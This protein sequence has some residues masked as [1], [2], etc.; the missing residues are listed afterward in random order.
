M[1]T[2]LPDDGGGAKTCPSCTK[3]YE[4]SLFVLPHNICHNC[5]RVITD[6]YRDD[7]LR[8]QK[9]YEQ[10]K[11]SGLLSLPEVVAYFE[12]KDQASTPQQ[13][14]MQVL[15]ERM[16]R[17]KRLLPYIEYNEP[18]YLAG[19][20]HKDICRRL[21]KFSQDVVDK[22]SPRLML[23]MPPRH[24]KSLIA[25]VNF[26]AWHLGNNPN[27]EIIACS[28]SASLAMK[29]S[30]K[31]RQQLR[32]PRY[33]ESFPNTK[34]SKDTQA[35]EEWLTTKGGGYVAAGVSGPITGKGAHVLIIDD[36]VKNRQDAESETKQEENIDWY[37]STAYTRLAP[38]GGVLIIL[39]RWHDADLAGKLI[40]MQGTG[41]DWEIVEYPAIATD[42]ELYRNKGEALHPDR[43][44]LAALTRIKNALPPRD[45]E[46]LYQQRP[47]AD[48]GD[49]FK[50]DD[51]RFF[52]PR[53]VDLDDMTY[54]QAW[55]LAIG[56][57]E[58][59]DYSVGVCVAVDREENLYVVDLVRGRWD[60][61]EL[62]EQI[63]DFYEL[64]R[65]GIVGIE[66][67]HINMAI[68]PFLNKRIHERRLSSMYVKDLAIGKRDKELRARSIQ[69]RLQ[70]G[71]LFLPEQESFTSDLILEMLR[72]PMGVHDDQVD[73]LAWSG[74]MM[75]EFSVIRD[76][77]PPKQKS[78]RDKLNKL[79]KISTNKGSAMS[80]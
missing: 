31:V 52:N 56:E 69:G 25:S 37:T 4:K 32:D 58:R 78:W 28:Y 66:R 2:E 17:R 50:R 57:K 11:T 23:F 49:Y 12:K 68:G 7:V 39:T 44:D 34:L 21:E 33:A 30:R 74:L 41:D 22:K 47:V 77:K 60:S 16:L 45:W 35:A 64:W 38:G 1:T 67:G 72:F 48:D 76:H 26:P 46:A 20:V 80:A 59:D 24:G 15:A 73:A 65:P 10:A 8:M 9:A 62:V 71:K 5:D 14:A 54:Y 42:D 75:E 18:N 79:S 19:W 70:Q 36:P 53:D 6:V 63:L 13:K 55:D 3:I 61:H 40:E 51:F 43:Y 27:H 29:F